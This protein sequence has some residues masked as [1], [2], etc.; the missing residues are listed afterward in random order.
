MGLEQNLLEQSK[1][2]LQMK[3]TKLITNKTENAALSASRRQEKLT[4]LT[5][6]TLDDK[7][8]DYTQYEFIRNTVKFWIVLFLIFSAISTS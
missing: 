2:D 3:K 4:W 7:A 1:P 5:K 8:D 6:I